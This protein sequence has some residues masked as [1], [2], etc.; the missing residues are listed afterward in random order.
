LN[1]EFVKETFPRPLSLYTP[2]PV[3]IVALYVTLP[4]N[5][6]ETTRAFA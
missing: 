1:P 3:S 2:S 5:E 6:V 4:Q